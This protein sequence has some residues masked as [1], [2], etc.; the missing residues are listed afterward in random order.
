MFGCWRLK[1][2]LEVECK[3]ERKIKIDKGVNNFATELT[4]F[5]KC[6]N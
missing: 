3:A 5:S 6:E 2:R 4:T 1:G